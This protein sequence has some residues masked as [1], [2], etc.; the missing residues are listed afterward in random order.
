[1]IIIVQGWMKLFGYP[2]KSFK[3]IRPYD[4]ALSDWDKGLTTTVF[5]VAANENQ[6]C[7]ILVVINVYGMGIDNQDIKFIIQ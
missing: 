1:M 7:V 5:I 4:F 2:E 3:W 6:K